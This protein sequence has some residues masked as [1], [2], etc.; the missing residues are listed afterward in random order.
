MLVSM[1]TPGSVELVDR[2]ARHLETMA[3]LRGVVFARCRPTN[4]L[5]VVV[6]PDCM[7]VLEFAENVLIERA[8]EVPSQGFV[9]FSAGHAVITDAVGGNRAETID[10]ASG[11]RTDLVF[12]FEDGSRFVQGAVWAEDGS[13]LAVNPDSSVIACWV[14]GAITERVGLGASS[15]WGHRSGDVLALITLDERGNENI[16]LFDVASEAMRHTAHVPSLGAHRLVTTVDGGVRVI[17]ND[18]RLNEPRNGDLPGGFET[19]IEGAELMRL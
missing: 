13:H 12:E 8:F 16:E 9:A 2:S 14:D 6:P 3:D 15:V 10:L 17:D 5:V 11:E 7:E 18:G 1:V 4:G 19:E